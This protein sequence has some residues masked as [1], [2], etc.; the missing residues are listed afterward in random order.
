MDQELKRQDLIV[1]NG[2]IIINGNKEKYNILL[3]DI[4]GEIE[5][6]VSLPS[7][8]KTTKY[9]HILPE[10]AV[11]QDDESI[12]GVLV[13]LNTLVLGGSHSIGVPLAVSGNVSFI[14][15]TA[16]MVVH[17]LRVSDTVLGVRQNYEYIERMQ[18]RIIQFTSCHSK[19]GEDSLRSIMFNTQEL[20]KDIG[21]VLVGKEAVECGI[22]DRIGGISAALNKLYDL[23]N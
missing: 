9:E 19:I 23:I 10:L 11:V 5:G 7:D 12:K 6:H 14:V 21:S 13:L 20:S 22:I 17:P 15:P 1:E 4:I 18:D 8:T 2:Q 16:T 3:L